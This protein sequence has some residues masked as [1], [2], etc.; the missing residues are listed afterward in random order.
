MSK[1]NVRFGVVAAIHKENPL[2]FDVRMPE[3]NLRSLSTAEKLSLSVGDTVEVF[4]PEGDQNRT[5]IR[6]KA[7]I[8]LGGPAFN[9]ILGPGEG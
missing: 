8:V 4:M 6:G 5:Y 9:R 3:G 2:L 7:P 1:D